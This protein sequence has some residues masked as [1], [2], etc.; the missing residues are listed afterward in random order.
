MP[1]E[2]R[3]ALRGDGVGHLEASGTLDLRLDALIASDA[4]AISDP[5]PVWRELRETTPVRRHGAV[6]LISSYDD[7]KRYSRDAINFSNRSAI[8]GS[9]F[10]TNRQRLDPRQKRAQSAVAEFESRYVSRSDGDQHDRLRSICHGAF[11]PRRIVEMEAAVTGFTEE[12][13]D[14][15][16]ADEPIDFRDRFAYRLPMLTISQMLGVP[17]DRQEEINRWSN[18]LA[19]N[20]GGDDPEAVLA[21]YEAMRDF[22]DYVENTVVPARRADPRTDLVSALLDAEGSERLTGEELIATFVVLLFAGHETTTNL[23]ALGLRELLRNGGQWRQLVD[24]PD[25]V[26]N[27]VEELLRWVTPVQ[28]SSRVS[29]VEQAIGGVEVARGDAVHLVL[30]AANRDPAVFAD[31]DTL[32]I[33]RSD[34]RDHLAFSFGPHFCLGSSLARLEAKIALEALVRRYPD[35]R[36]AGEPQSWTGAAMLRTVTDLPLKM[37]RDRG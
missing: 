16:P 17:E 25:L 29:T 10:E 9:L 31:P 18:S 11:T 20:R 34:A 8:D 28:W 14:G 32:D 13:L 22:R 36:L 5:F 35:V 4:D 24:E 30:A 27:A 23:I 6:V 21:A 1:M 12:L 3:S 15:L 33:T 7:V 37:G 2:V 26:G 19:R